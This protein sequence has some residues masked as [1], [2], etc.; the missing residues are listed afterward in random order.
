MSWKVTMGFLS[1]IC[2]ILAMAIL[3]YQRTTELAEAGKSVA[4]SNEVLTELE[5]TVSD[6]TEVEASVRGFLL[7]GGDAYLTT[8]RQGAAGVPQRLQRLRQ[9]TADNPRQQAR[10][11]E[12]ETATQ[13]K[14]DWAAQL[15]NVYQKEDPQAALTMMRTG[16]GESLMG[17]VRQVASTVGDEED[18]LLRS[19]TQQAEVKTRRAT[20]SLRVLAVTILLVLGLAYHHVR[21][22]MHALARVQFD[23]ARSRAQLEEAL[24]REQEISRVDPLTNVANRRAFYE[25]LESESKRARR[26]GRPLSVAYLDIDSFKEVNDS[27]GHATGDALLAAVAKIIHT[28]IRAGCC[29]ARFGGDEFALM[30]PDVPLPEVE[31]SIKRLRNLLLEEMGKRG[32]PVSFSIGAVVFSKPSQSVDDMVKAADNQMYAI[33]NKSKNGLSVITADESLSATPRPNEQA[34]SNAPELTKVETP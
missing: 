26:Y 23:L 8:W 14:L 20:T 21:Q 34:P 12:L 33:K 30:I 13:R 9:L 25:T 7:T 27:F 2:I 16:H 22:E 5:G 6:V 1:A 11:R 17:Q 31:L 15:V 19:R 28:N 32:W 10:L 4:H 29:V 18:A 24:Q 3:S